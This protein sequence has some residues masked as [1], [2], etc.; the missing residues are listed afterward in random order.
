MSLSKSRLTGVLFQGTNTVPHIPL[1]EAECTM[2]ALSWSHGMC[3]NALN[4]TRSPLI[5]GAE[6][7]RSTGQISQRVKVVLADGL[8]SVKHKSLDLR[9]AFLAHF[10]CFVNAAQTFLWKV[11]AHVLQF[12]MLFSSRGTFPAV[13]RWL[14]S[15]VVASSTSIREGQINEGCLALVRLMRGRSQLEP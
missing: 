10:Y 14:S 8:Y 3:I 4:C 1:R 9:V 11:E 6:L 12:G 13:F 15:E 5:D 7:F 2:R